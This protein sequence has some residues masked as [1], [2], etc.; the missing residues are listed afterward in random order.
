MIATTIH[1]QTRRGQALVE[2]AVL[3]GLIAALV[4][5]ALAVLE[6]A[7]AG[8]LTHAASSLSPSGIG[9]QPPP[10]PGDGGNIGI[11]R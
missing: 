6:P 11:H 9:V 2:Y 8:A 4:L 1:P 10:F 5:V 7:I 3:L